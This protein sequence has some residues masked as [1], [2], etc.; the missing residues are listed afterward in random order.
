VDIRE[1]WVCLDDPLAVEVFMTICEE[2]GY[3]YLNGS[4]PKNF[5]DIQRENYLRG[6]RDNSRSFFY[7]YYVNTHGKI[8]VVK[9][10]DNV[11]CC[12]SSG[13]NVNSKFTL[14]NM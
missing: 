3:T 8:L 2:Q 5:I 9:Y 13:F 10:T 7:G 4:K 6:I 1:K 14:D 11:C 12:M